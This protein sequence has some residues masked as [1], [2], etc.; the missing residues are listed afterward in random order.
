MVGGNVPSVVNDALGGTWDAIWVATL[1]IGPATLLS[2]ILVR[3]QWLGT[4]LRCAGG[5]ATLGA[6]AAFLAAVAPTAGQAFTTWAAGGLCAATAWL[7]ARDLRLWAHI[8]RTDRR[9]R[10]H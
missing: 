8:Y 6:L 9:K 3:D 7:L 10:G 2:G 5:L 4:G 1:I